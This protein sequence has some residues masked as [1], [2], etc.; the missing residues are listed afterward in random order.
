MAG[1]GVLV[2]AI[3]V[4][5]LAP[6]QS[7]QILEGSS[8]GRADVSYASRQWF[9]STP[10]NQRNIMSGVWT[11]K[12]G[13][14]LNIS[15]MSDD[16][17]KNTEDMLTRSVDRVINLDYMI[18]TEGYPGDMRPISSGML[19]RLQEIREE[20]ERRNKLNA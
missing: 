3:R 20:I 2:P 18:S 4:R 5:V 16:H 7:Q 17:L 15:D 1:R 12:D 13:R 6:Q 14:Q 9:N 10:S 11:T 8:G 19:D